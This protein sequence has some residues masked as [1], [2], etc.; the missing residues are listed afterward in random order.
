MPSGSAGPGSAVQAPADQARSQPGPA[1]VSD[2]GTCCGSCQRACGTAKP[3]HREDEEPISQ[4]STLLLDAAAREWISGSAVT[5][6]YSRGMLALVLLAASAALSHGSLP[7]LMRA[8]E[9][10]SGNCSAP[11]FA[12]LQLQSVPTPVPSAD[13]QVLIRVAAA[14][15]NP[16]D[17]DFV[18]MG[19]APSMGVLGNDIAGTVVMCRGCSRLAVGDQVW[20][21]PGQSFAEYSVCADTEREPERLP[22]QSAA[23]SKNG[24]RC[25]TR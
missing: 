13:G 6:V 23:S 22:K 20:G 9:S 7:S 25:T 21:S 19:L 15:L 11:T 10:A 18:E 16:S 12:C 1:V 5:T 4:L 14:G 24:I 3:C 2:T 17:V 8:V